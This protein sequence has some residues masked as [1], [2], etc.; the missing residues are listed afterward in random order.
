MRKHM[1]TGPTPDNTKRLTAGPPNSLNKR[2]SEEPPAPVMLL[3]LPWSMPP[4]HSSSNKL[5]NTCVNMRK[6]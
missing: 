4:G 6:T 2:V 5:L 3:F 1:A